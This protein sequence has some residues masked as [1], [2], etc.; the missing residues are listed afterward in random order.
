[1]T[2]T[3]GGEPTAARL[4]VDGRD[5]ADLEVARSARARRRGLLGRDRIDGAIWLEP[6][7]HVHSLGMRV[8]LDVAFVARDGTVL[9]VQH[10]RRNRLARLV[11]RTRVVVEAGSGSFSRWGLVPGSRLVRP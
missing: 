1:V 11:P 10:L 5:V 7:L 8:D 3:G 6:A 2:P 9:A 4:V